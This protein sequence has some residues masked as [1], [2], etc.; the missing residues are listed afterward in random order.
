MIDSNSFGKTIVILRLIVAD[1]FPH[2]CLVTTHLTHAPP[3]L[4]VGF[5]T[6]LLFFIVNLKMMDF[7]FPVTA[8]THTYVYC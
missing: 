7:L 1:V 8:H 4:D 2:W 3:R 5:Y 6:D